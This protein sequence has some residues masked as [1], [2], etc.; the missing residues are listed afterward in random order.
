MTCQELLH[1]LTEYAEGA[2]PRNLCE[3]IRMHIGTCASCAELERDLADL[4]RLCRECDPPRLPEDLKRR[5]LGRI[6]GETPRP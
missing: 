1:R 2:L 6:R 5:L 4:A 3:E